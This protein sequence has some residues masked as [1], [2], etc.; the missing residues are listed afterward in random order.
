MSEP[1][2][3]M[4]DD[5]LIEYALEHCGAGKEIE[6]RRRAALMLHDE[7]TRHSQAAIVVP[8]GAS[9]AEHLKALRAKIGAM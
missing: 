8:P 1:L 4:T 6:E 5:E 3:R 9:E 2:E 7:R